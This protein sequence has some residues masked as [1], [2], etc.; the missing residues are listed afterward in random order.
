ME[1]TNLIMCPTC[2]TKRGFPMPIGE[3]KDGRVYIRRHWTDYTV[4]LGKDFAL[5][6]GGC[7]QVVFIRDTKSLGTVIVSQGSAIL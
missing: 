5:A 7:N 2:R 4:V 6:C 1:K 3:I